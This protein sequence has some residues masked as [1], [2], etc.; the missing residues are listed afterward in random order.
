MPEPNCH[1]P[2][3]NN[4]KPEVF[5]I[6]CATFP[7]FSLSQLCPAH[8]AILTI[9]EDSLI[10]TWVDQVGKFGDGWI[11]HQQDTN[12]NTST[13]DVLLYRSWGVTNGEH[14]DTY[15]DKICSNGKPR[16][17]PVEVNQDVS[18]SR[19]VRA[20]TTPLRDLLS[21]RQPSSSPDFNIMKDLSSS[22]LPLRKSLP[23][24]PQKLSLKSS[25][26]L[27]ALKPSH[28]SKNTQCWISKSLGADES[29]SDDEITEDRLAPASAMAPWPLMFFSKMAEG[30]HEMVQMS[31][32][33]AHRFEAGFPMAKFR[34]ATW[35]KHSN[36]YKLATPDDMQC[37]CTP[38]GLWKRFTADM[39]SQVDQAIKDGAIRKRAKDGVSHTRVEALIS[40]RA[41]EQ[42]LGA[43][44]NDCG[45]VKSEFDLQHDLECEFCSHDLPTSPSPQLLILCNEIDISAKR[46]ATKPNE[47]LGY[48]SSVVTHC[49]CHKAERTYELQSADHKW[50]LHI[51]FASLGHCVEALHSPLLQV[52]QF[53]EDNQFF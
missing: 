33:L 29:D 27:G 32:T 2:D 42:S 31:G 18:R 52:W 19:T 45:A 39:R 12:Q 16:K 40:Q 36:L 44:G 41:L 51:N 6:P 37:Y 25:S 8:K 17:H 4:C 5:E 23:S 9:D 47:L 34:K 10:E 35:S 53:P 50:P 38:D 13:N 30:I 21:D 24:H 26:A 22:P 43:L 14:M 15:L 7:Y 46:K 3:Q 28:Q 20:Q 11:N 1:S 49:M 48:I